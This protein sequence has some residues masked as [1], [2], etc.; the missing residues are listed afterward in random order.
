MMQESSESNRNPNNWREPLKGWRWLA[1]W[2]LLFSCLTIVTRFLLSLSDYKPNA[3]GTASTWVLS[4]GIA[5]AV[6]VLL[7]ILS[8]SLSSFHGFKRLL[9]ALACVLGLVA[10]F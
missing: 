4:I 8:C 9:V 1:A 10:L 2:A 3:P 7:W 6:M 5:L